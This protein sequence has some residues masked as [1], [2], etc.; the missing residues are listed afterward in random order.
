MNEE[1]DLKQIIKNIYERKNILAY[2]LM[3]SIVIGIF[4]TFI[5]KRPEYQI[6][7]EILIDKADISIED[8][9]SGKDVINGKNIEAT[10]DKTS[11]VITVSALPNKK[12][13]EQSLK[14]VNSYINDLQVK[15]EE[16]YGIKKFTII[17]KPQIPEKATNASYIKDIG[18]CAV[19]GI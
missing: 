7:A 15:L 17:E 10:F 18:V 8:F 16:I 4:Y 11:K 19:V 13:K 12:E 1:L 9:V 14:E 6:T 5:I 2:I 3:I